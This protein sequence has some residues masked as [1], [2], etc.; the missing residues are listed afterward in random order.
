[1]SA[2]RKPRKVTNELERTTR[3]LAVFNK[4]IQN[5]QR[6]KMEL[7][8]LISNMRIEKKHA[9][10]TSKECRHNAEKFHQASCTISKVTDRKENNNDMMNKEIQMVKMHI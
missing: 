6:E 7:K 2:E 8:A 4:N 5:L 3:Q 10:K 9:E 1:M